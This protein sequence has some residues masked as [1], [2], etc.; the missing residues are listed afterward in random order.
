M[1][2]ACHPEPLAPEGIA[3]FL[4]EANPQALRARWKVGPFQVARSGTGGRFAGE[5]QYPPGDK[6]EKRTYPGGETHI[7]Y[8][9]LAIS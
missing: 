6:S 3:D 2:L 8:S 7:W 9:Q 1:G 4:T 5:R